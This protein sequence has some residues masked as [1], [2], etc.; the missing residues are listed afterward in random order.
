MSNIFH[1][2]LY[3]PLFNL[4]I[5][6]Y[7]SIP[8]QDLAIAIILLTLIVKIV[9]S[10]LS[11]K[12]FK[13]QKAMSAIQPK[14]KEL[15][16]KHKGDK[17]A[18]AQAQMGLF[19]EH[20]VNPLGGCLPILIQLPV[21]WVLYKVFMNGLK[22]G[23]LDALYSFIHNPGTINTVGFGFLDLAHA[24]PVLAIATGVAQAIQSWI[25][26]KLQKTQG[27][28]PDDNPA[29]KMTQNMMY[30]FPI[31]IVFISW[32]LPAGLVLYWLTSTLWS[33]LEQTYIKRRH[34]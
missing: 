2:A 28:I 4:L 34:A 18:F 13:S 11:V 32:S 29:L 25:S 12:M 23:S 7:N 22:D 3:R 31:M 33:I 16:E 24:N 27:S 15:Q 6:I 9:L 5:G 10:P 17:Q 14:I 1:E 26:I 20:N 8:G 21:I 30:F 19:K